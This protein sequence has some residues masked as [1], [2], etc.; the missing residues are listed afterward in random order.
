MNHKI[1]AVNTAPMMAPALARAS[2][3]PSAEP[4]AGTHGP[5]EGPGPAPGPPAAVRSAVSRLLHPPPDGL[6]H[7]DIA[8]QRGAEQGQAACPLLGA[9]RQ[10]RNQADLRSEEH[11]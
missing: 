7:I 6:P 8:G 10:R 1:T 11:T 2:P 4:P 9:Q 3:P 5:D